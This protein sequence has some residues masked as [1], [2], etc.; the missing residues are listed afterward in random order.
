MGHNL[1]EGFIGIL[2]QENQKPA[3]IILPLRFPNF[4]KMRKGDQ[5]LSVS[6]YD[7]RYYTGLQVTKDPGV[8]VV[9][10]GFML[11]IAGC[12]II[13]FMSHQSVC[14]EV[15]RSGKKTS[16]M[17]SGI[18][19]KNKL[20]MQKRIDKISRRLIELDRKG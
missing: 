11:M 5:V 20:G 4:D 16:V 18:A 9:Y 19:E 6:G 17:V 3:E 12:F 14:V 7:E 2:V 1:G 8:W 10:S 15:L 13:F